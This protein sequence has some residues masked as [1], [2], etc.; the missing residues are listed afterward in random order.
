MIRRSFSILSSF[1]S[2]EVS[3]KMISTFTFCFNNVEKI[4]PNERQAFRLDIIIWFH[5]IWAFTLSHYSKSTFLF[6]LTFCCLMIQRRQNTLRLLGGIYPPPQ[7]SAL[8]SMLDGK[9]AGFPGALPPGDTS[10]YAGGRGHQCDC[11]AQLQ[12]IAL[13]ALHSADSP[14]PPSASARGALL[15][16]CHLLPHAAC[17]APVSRSSALLL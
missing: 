2:G 13:H 15:S 11:S 8:E 10:P 1:S 3:N 7:I 4:L 17:Q 12:P 14:S 6:S 16:V 9:G 5:S